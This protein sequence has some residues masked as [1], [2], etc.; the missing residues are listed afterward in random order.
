MSRGYETRARAG[1]RTTSSEPDWRRRAIVENIL[2]YLIL[3]KKESGNF[4]AAQF[5]GSILSGRGTARSRLD[6][7][8][9]SAVQPAGRRKRRRRT[10]F[11]ARLGI[12]GSYKRLLL[13]GSSLF[14][15]SYLSGR[16]QNRIVVPW[17][18]AKPRPML[19][20]NAA[21]DRRM[22][23]IDQEQ[24]H[25]SP[26]RRGLIHQKGMDDVAQGSGELPVE[27][28]ARDESKPPTRG[29]GIDTGGVPVHD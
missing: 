9:Q 13:Q 15:I 23:R 24:A 6:T 16:V 14:F 10:R 1:Y 20:R 4:V 22:R 17:E 5:P 3:V 11:R 19:A 26:A 27:R 7:T 25:Q 29:R 2:L 28:P 12:V 18:E 21:A 8:T